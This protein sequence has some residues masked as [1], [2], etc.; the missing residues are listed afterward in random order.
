MPRPHDKIITDIAK[1]SLGSVGFHRK[2]RS[3]LWFADHGWWLTL[4]EFQPSAWSKG[5]YVNV[6]AQ[7]LW[8]E[9]D[10]FTFDFG[11][12]LAEF[13][14]FKSEEEFT[15]SVLCLA[16]SALHEAQRLRQTFGSLSETA[17]ALLNEAR[18]RPMLNAGHPGWMAYHAGVAAGLVGRSE[19][20]A[21][22]FGL[23]LNDPT[24]PGSLLHSTAKRTADLAAEP[25]RLRNEVLSVIKHQRDTL[26]LPP[27]DAQPL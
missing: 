6:A 25:P 16:E 15:P 23:I 22:M 21:E 17:D 27:L 1:M 8:F 13:A 12:R 19:D 14:E 4:I 2:G 26:R 20:A 7:W 9:A 11:G 24:L 3:R 10:T 18:T 5:S